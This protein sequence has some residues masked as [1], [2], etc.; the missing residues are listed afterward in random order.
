M[1]GFLE[2]KS[3]FVQGLPKQPDGLLVSLG[4]LPLSP[5]SLV[6]GFQALELGTASGV[7]CPSVP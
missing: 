4:N 2:L 7:R 1:T 6:P 5:I 3:V